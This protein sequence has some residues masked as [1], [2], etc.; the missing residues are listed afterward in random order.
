MASNFSIATQR[1]EIVSI[2]KGN[3]HS[4][5]VKLAAKISPEPLWNT[6][7]EVSTQFNTE[8]MFA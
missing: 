4:L 5:W 7:E 2:S 1:P 8:Q 6:A 3:F